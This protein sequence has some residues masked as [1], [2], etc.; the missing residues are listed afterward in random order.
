MALLSELEFDLALGQPNA[1]HPPGWEMT[2]LLPLVVEFMAE[3][4]GAHGLEIRIDGKLQRDIVW[5]YI[6]KTSA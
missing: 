4:E 2:M 3:A 5:W 6:R 1:Q